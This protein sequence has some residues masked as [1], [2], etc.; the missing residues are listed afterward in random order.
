M[1][2]K[3]H[4]NISAF[5]KATVTLLALFVLILISS[6]SPETMQ[7]CTV[8]INLGEEKARSL[9]AVIDPLESYTIY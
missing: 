2:D 9:S 6:C 5:R 4:K 1:K 8:S 3:G 7:L